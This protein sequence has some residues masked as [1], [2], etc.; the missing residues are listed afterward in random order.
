MN[1]KLRPCLALLAVAMLAFAITPTWG[2]YSTKAILG[3]VAAM[4]LALAACLLPDWNLPVSPL[5]TR[6]GFPIGLL[7]AV[8]MLVTALAV[9]YGQVFYS[10]GDTI[11]DRALKGL[12]I[13]GCFLVASFLFYFF[14]SWGKYPELLWFQLAGLFLTGVAIRIIAVCAV[15]EPPIDVF[16]ALRD[17]P[18]HLLAGRNPYTADYFHPYP[19][20]PFSYDRYPFYPPLPIL[21]GLPFHIAG[22][23]VRLANVVC[24]L[25]AAWVLWQTARSRG[26]PLAGAFAAGIY[27][28]FPR[29]PF[30]MEQAWYEPMLAATL[31]T[32]LYL[33]ERIHPSERGKSATENTSPPFA[34]TLL[35]YFL[36]G[37]GLTGKQY[38]I[39]LLPPLV[40]SQ[41][42]NWRLLL[43]GVVLASL[44]VIG[45]FFLWNPR[46]FLEVIL[47]AFL[48]RPLRV[49]S[50]TILVGVEDMFQFT[51]KFGLG[52]PRA[53]FWAIA[54]IFIGL[55]TWRTPAKTTASALWLGTALLTFC[56]FHTQGFFN[57]FYLCEYLFLLG[58]VGLI[59]KSSV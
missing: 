11:A 4:L 57:Y 1:P 51:T 22:L 46:A 23:D 39:V 38:G 52:L 29:V 18:A 35:G 2:F 49:D 12:P 3:A 21:F 53:L 36:L 10:H 19:H 26:C 15:P 32:G 37:L 34:K 44:T 16:F 33:V 8:A 42:R 6:H 9:F 41:W 31:G 54:M 25:L 58:I 56:L 7:G 47:F 50:I 27:L 13:G 59:P 20:P 30:L 24:D 45:P 14:S 43:L 55:I 17:G 40:K 48:D 5:P 28:H